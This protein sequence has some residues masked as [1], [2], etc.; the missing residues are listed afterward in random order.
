M[1]ELRLDH[2]AFQL[3]WSLE[4]YFLQDEGE[5][6]ESDYQRN[7]EK[8]LENIDLDQERGEEMEK[9]QP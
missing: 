4:N 9:Y 5:L 7:D 2:W 3:S 1:E 8:E 6:S